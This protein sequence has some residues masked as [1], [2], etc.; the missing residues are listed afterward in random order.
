MMDTRQEQLAYFENSIK[1]CWSVVPHFNKS[2][3][4]CALYE[5]ARLNNAWWGFQAGVLYMEQKGGLPDGCVAVHKTWLD[6]IRKT[7][8]EYLR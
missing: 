7:M 6:G 2:T 1:Q 5:D 4:E 3:D 8:K